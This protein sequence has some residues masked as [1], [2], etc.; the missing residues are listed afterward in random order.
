MCAALKYVGQSC[1]TP[2]LD[3][4]SPS[5]PSYPTPTPFVQ[6][7]LMIS[8]TDTVRSVIALTRFTLGVPALLLDNQP[9]ARLYDEAGME[10]RDGV[11]GRLEV[12]D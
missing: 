4:T 2:G 12:R 10:V 7:A 9:P 6:V 1:L 5:H 8:Y 3:L 11:T